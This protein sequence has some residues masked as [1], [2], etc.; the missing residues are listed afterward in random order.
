MRTA[1]NKDRLAYT[2]LGPYVAKKYEEGMSYGQVSKEVGIPKGCVQNLCRI[3]GVKARENRTTNIPDV[4]EKRLQDYVLRTGVRVISRPERLTKKSRILTRCIHGI[5]ERPCQV[6]E[7]MTFCCKSGSKSGLN[8]PSK[9]WGVIPEYRNLPGTL[10]LI[11]YLDQSGTHFK[12]GITKH[13]VSRR[14][15][16]GQLISILHLHHA[17]LGECFDLEQAILKW[18]K[19]NN[20]RYS[21]PTTT[22]LIRPEAYN[23]ILERLI[24]AVPT[25]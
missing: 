7:S 1:W 17:T 3:I 18:A 11:R 13:S 6:L 9:G 25:P 8:N 19:G 12:I 14:F 15:N 4:W 23:F 16:P 21:S 24:E 2:P 5:S 20:Y 22:E 10:Y